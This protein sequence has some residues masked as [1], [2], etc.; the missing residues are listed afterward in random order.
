MNLEGS[1]RID[2]PKINEIRLSSYTINNGGWS[3]DFCITIWDRF[4]LDK[5]DALTYQWYQVG[6]LHGGFSSIKG[7]LFFYYHNKRNYSCERAFIKTET[8]R[9]IFFIITGMSI[10]TCK[11]LSKINFLQIPSLSLNDV[12]IDRGEKVVNK[13]ESFLIQRNIDDVH[14]IDVYAKAYNDSHNNNC[15]H[16]DILFYKESSKTNLDN[17]K[18]NPRVVDRYSN[19]ND[20]LYQYEWIRGKFA[21]RLKF[22]NGEIVEMKQSLE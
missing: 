10:V 1:E 8:M 11:K 15:A 9:V 17:I 3:A 2:N 7:T 14:K 19:D 6:L 21:A 4:G 18:L 12:R 20:L 22:R 5:N 16:F 13:A